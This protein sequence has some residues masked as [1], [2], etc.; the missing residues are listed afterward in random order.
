MSHYL[1]CNLI[2]PLQTK[3]N[4]HFIFHQLSLK[5]IQKHEGNKKTVC[6]SES[7]KSLEAHSKVRDNFWQLKAF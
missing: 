7:K 6:L 5:Y 2:L 1:Y 4:D 3:K